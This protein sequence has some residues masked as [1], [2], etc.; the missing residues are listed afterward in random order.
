[1]SPVPKTD[2]SSEEHSNPPDTPEV[3]PWVERF[4]RAG[5]WAKGIVYVII[6]GLA[7][8]LAIG[9]GGR[10]TGARGAIRE[11]GQQPFGRILLGLMAVG[12]I[13]Y[14]GWRW[15]QAAQDTE[16]VGKGAKGI[17]LRI[18]FVVSGAVYFVLGIFAG[19]IA[20]AGARGSSGGDNSGRTT[21]LLD[22]MP[23]RIGLGALAVVLIGLAIGFVY[24]GYQAKFMRDYPIDS[25]SEKMRRVALQVGRVGMSTR[26]VAFAIAG[27]FVL[28]S[29]ITG[30]S[31]GEIS[32]IADALAAVAA[33]PHGKALLGIAGFGVVCFGAHTILLGI[34]RRFNA[35]RR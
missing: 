21:M 27:W 25:M 3:A 10:I 16:G 14:A 24:Q 4:G 17:A 30:T 28:W 32:G 33:R 7:F 11:I 8:Q 1:M 20:V 9:S 22:S 26:G 34:H 5:Y 35:T 19:S 13:A 23:G 6:G 12:L 31:N 18:G 2:R 15:L 29:A